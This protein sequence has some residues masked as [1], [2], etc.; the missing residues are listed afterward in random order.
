M[1]IVKAGFPWAC[2]TMALLGLLAPGAHADDVADFYRGKNIELQIGFGPGGGNDIWGRVI[3]RNIT[4]YIPGNPTVVPKNV[5]SAGR[6]VVA[7]TIYNAAPKD[8]TVIG[9]IDRGIPFESLFHGKGVQFDSLKF[10]YLGSP[11]RDSNMCAVWSTNPVKMAKD[12]YER[13]ISI[14]A[15]GSG[16]ESYVFP[17]ILKNML[18]MK[19]DIVKGYK[20][21]QDILLAV[22]RQELDGLCVG[23]ETLHRTSQYAAGKYRIVL[24]MA[25]EPDPTLTDIPLVTSFA[26]TEEDRAVLNLIFA[27]VNVGRPFVA[28]PDMPKSRV[29]ALSTA[30][31]D[32]MKDA[33]FRKEVEH[34]KLEINAI[35]GSQLEQLVR[36]AYTT[37]EKV[38]ERTSALLKQ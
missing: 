25:T 16:A 7:N 8:G 26:K 4:R 18:G 6:L 19:V 20:G 2:A 22:E 15:T 37:P 17:L 36:K 3:G 1:R 11:S 21:T 13:S 28:P 38:V 31:G 12:L 23:T 30:F 35:T 5:P 10:N 33:D 29:E 32:T 24:Q 34:L 14:G 27:R 9:M